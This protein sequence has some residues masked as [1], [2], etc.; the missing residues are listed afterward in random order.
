MLKRS[1]NIVVENKLLFGIFAF[2][3]FLRL[4]S[5]EH[6]F[7]N[8]VHPDEPTIVRSAL[9]IRFFPNPKHF[10]W[11]H[12]YIYLN[13]FVYMLFAWVRNILAMLGLKSTFSNIF[14]LLWN[15]DLIF[16][17]ISRIFSSFLGALTVF[18]VYLA[19]LNLFKN[20][21]VAIFSA[22]VMAVLPYHIWH[23]QYSLADVPMTFFLAM[24]MYFCTHI[25]KSNKTFY[26][27]L[28]GLFVGFA[29]S[30][31]YNGGLSALI[32]LTAHL[33]RVY[34]T[35]ERLF[36]IENLKN[37]FL[38]GTF[39][40][41]GFVM[42][43]PYALLDFSTFIRTDGPKGA[44]WQFT[45]VGKVSLDLQ[46]IKFV[47][48]FFTKLPDDF[49]FMP[50][51]AYLTVVLSLPFKIVR[52][53]IF[54]HVEPLLLLIIPSLIFFFYIAGFEKSRS[55]YYFITYPLVAVVAG[56]LVHKL[57]DYVG[58][59]FNKKVQM[60]MLLLFFIFPLIVII[61]NTI[62]RFESYNIVTEE[63]YETK[64]DY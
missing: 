8:I 42:G 27:I 32:V 31:K 10:D 59:S 52:N 17:L 47:S 34:S 43:T 57:F 58:T 4:L 12:L 16:Y 44:L 55:H 45:N 20:K 39:S 63:T 33:L 5:I 26:Y 46:V 62:S 61:Q 3:L 30:T 50:L 11:P 14:P 48:L 49:G 29:A 24:A 28:A 56:Y 7:P 64:E 38:S 6:S 40:L 9:G 13:Y 22:L 1:K 19:A 41:I 23:S 18:P 53:F 36:S 54:V 51:I 35:K 2:T 21:K 25:F 60:L 37:L 15:D